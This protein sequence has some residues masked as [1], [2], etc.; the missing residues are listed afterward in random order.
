[1]YMTSEAEITKEVVKK[2]IMAALILHA[3]DKF[4]HGGLKG[5]L[6]QH[7]LMGTNHPLSIQEFLHVLN[8]YNKTT[9]RQPLL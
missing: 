9:R 8:T 6:A 3:A 7:M 5:T 2:E 4:E 1:M